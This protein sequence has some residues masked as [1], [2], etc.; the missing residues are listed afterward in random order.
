MLRTYLMQHMR[1]HPQTNHF[2]PM[3]YKLTLTPLQDI[4]SKTP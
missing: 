4:E 2:R 1:N 3:P